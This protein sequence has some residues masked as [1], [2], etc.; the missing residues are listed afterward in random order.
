MKCSEGRKVA[1]KNGETETG[2]D[3]YC[4]G[5]EV[6]Y[7]PI[8]T[9]PNTMHW[10]KQTMFYLFNWYQNIIFFFSETEYDNGTEW[11]IQIT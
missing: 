1:Y 5:S 2:G 7:W 4:Q 9:P 3:R 10:F 6:K 8:I 11:N